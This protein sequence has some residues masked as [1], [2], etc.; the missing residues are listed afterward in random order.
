MPDSHTDTARTA[1]RE[2]MVFEMSY[3]ICMREP[4]EGNAKKAL[5][6]L[7]AFT[8]MRPDGIWNGD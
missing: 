5:A 2:W 6:Q 8:Q 1:A 7:L 3:D 4:T